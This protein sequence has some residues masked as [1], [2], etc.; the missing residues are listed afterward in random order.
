M[1]VGLACVAVGLPRS[2][3]YRPLLDRLE[4][5]KP[6]IEALNG[7]VTEN[8]G[9]GFWK[10]NDRLQMENRGWNHKRVYRVYREMKLN[11]R[12]RAKKRVLT[13]LPQPLD[14]VAAPNETWA[15]D[16]MHGTL[17]VGRRFRTLNVLDEGVREVLDIEIDMSLTGE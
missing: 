5:D 16:F 1:S 10:C 14:V 13:R 6:V 8:A 17:Y 9:W 7:L 15:L 12:R 2:S 3:W 11:I 4:R